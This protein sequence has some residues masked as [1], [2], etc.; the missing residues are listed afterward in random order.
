MDK[1]RPSIKTKKQNRLGQHLLKTGTITSDHLQE[2]LKRQSQIGGKLGSSLIEMGFI[3]V[4][5]LLAFLS[6]KFGVPGINLFSVNIGAE[7]LALVPIDKMNGL[8]ILPISTDAASITLAMADPLALDAVGD[9]QFNLGKKVKPVVAPDFMIQAALQVIMANPDSP[10]V[11]ATLAGIIEIGRG[12]KLPS[13]K[14]LLQYMIKCGANDML[15]TTG[16]PPSVKISNK[17]KRLSIPAL[18]PADC[19]RYARDLLPFKEW[20]VFSKKTDHGLGIS[21]P[22]I[23][24]FRVTL[25]RQRD[26]IAAAIRPISETIPSLEKLNLPNWIADFA[27]RPNGLVLVSGPAGHGKST[28]LSAMIDIINRQRGCNIVTLEDPIEYLHKHKKS[29]VNQREIGRDVASFSEGMRHVLRQAPDVIVVGE[30]RDRETFEIALRAASSGHLILSTVHSDN[31]TSI[32]ERVVNMFEPHEQGIVRMMLADSFLL[33]LS[34]RLVPLKTGQGRILALEKLTNTS[35]VKKMIREEKTHQ[36]RSQMQAGGQ[37][38][39]PLDISLAEL[40]KKGLIEKTAGLLFCEDQRLYDEL[41][42]KV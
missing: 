11:G 15:L 13:L 6:S 9:L 42:E 34:Q 40:V 21:F 12:E 17:L 18:T 36:I 41:V 2:G 25:Y 31:A 5:D 16:T 14:M 26:A 29:N 4:E 8:K 20:E 7:V 38:F 3:A 24:R 1:D 37:D 30:M 28:T 32:F 19:E 22:G 35:R 23:G 33:S 27:L 39:I 10:F